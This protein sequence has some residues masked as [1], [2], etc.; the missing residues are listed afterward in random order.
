[1]SI[2]SSLRPKLPALL[3]STLLLAGIEQVGAKGVAQEDVNP[4]ASSGYTAK[5]L[6]NAPH[7]MVASANPLAT[8]AG[9]QILRQGGSAI[10]AAIA[11]QLVLNLVEPQSSGIGGGAFVV[12]Y[13]AGQ[14]KLRTY[15]GRETAPA[16]AAPERFMQGARPLQ[17]ARAIN[18]GRSVGAPGLLRVLELA[19]KKHGK[20]PWAA[21]FEPAIVLAEKGFP[22]SPRLHQLIVKNKELPKQAAAAAYFMPAGQPLPI[23]HLLKNPALAGVLRRVANEGADAFYRGEIARNIVRAVRGHPVPGDLSEQDLAAYQAKEREPVCGHY[24]AFKICGMPPPSSGSIAVL[25]MLGMLEQHP[26]ASIKPNTVEAVHYFSEAGRLAF[27]DR[28]YYVGDPDFVKVPVKALLDPAYLQRRGAL[29]RPDRSMGVAQPGDPDGK[30]A[31]Q[32]KDDA[33]ET[34]ATSHI[35]AVDREG[36]GLTMTTTI[37]S[38]FGS[39]IFVDGFLLNNELTDFSLSPQDEQGRP[40]ANRVEPGKRPRSS[41]APMVVF[42]NGKPKMLVGSPGGSAIINYV[43]KTL[44]GVLDWGLNMQDAISLPNM[45]SRN[46]ET[47]LEKGTVLEALAPGLVSMG[48][49]VN[50]LEFPS[51]LQGIVIGDKRLSGGADPR[52]EGAVKGD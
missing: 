12:F 29:I 44:V 45:G 46:K 21:L 4:E 35:V 32:G 20:L 2:F 8:D 48:H 40:V 19:H 10:D 50:I 34:P 28:D 36:N 16:A 33:L 27:A 11:T 38:E 25:Q 24:R 17:I 30:L 37:E 43:A 7:F 47:E 31:M 51:G 6:V 15:D 1:M 18:S 5:E 39:K 14:K 26:M 42:E 52:R 13:D 22:V 23:G 3:A 41:M 49:T 9:Y